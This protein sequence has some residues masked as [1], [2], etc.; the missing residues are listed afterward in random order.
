MKGTANNNRVYKQ[1]S[2]EIDRGLVFACQ[3]LKTESYMVNPWLA[4]DLLCRT[5]WPYFQETHR[6]LPA[7]L[8]L[9]REQLQVKLLDFTELQKLS[10]CLAGFF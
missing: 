5:G 2:Y 8:C 6:D 7:R 4:R 10:L 9:L 3:F 1:V